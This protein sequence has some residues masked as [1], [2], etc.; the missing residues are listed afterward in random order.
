MVIDLV[1]ATVW[2]HICPARWQR[3]RGLFKSYHRR[4]P[5]ADDVL[6][7]A[8]ALPLR[9]GLWPVCLV[10]LGSSHDLL[11]HIIAAHASCPSCP[12]AL[13]NQ[14]SSRSFF[15]RFSPER[16]PVA[17]HG[18]LAV[19]PL[20][21]SRCLNNGSYVAMRGKSGGRPSH[22]GP[23]RIFSMMAHLVSLR[24]CVTFSLGGFHPDFLVNLP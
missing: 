9:A 4:P 13:A 5:A 15:Y 24:S 17:L 23:P 22:G 1:P 10:P 21:A 14:Y 16:L 3:E 18:V 8:A 20:L 7:K 12:H 19:G 2:L 11:S 6:I